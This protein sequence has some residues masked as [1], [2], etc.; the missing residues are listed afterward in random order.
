MYSANKHKSKK[1]ARRSRRRGKSVNKKHV[2]KSAKRRSPKRKSP[3]RKS[4]KRKSPKR[5]SLKGGAIRLPSEYF[6]KMSGRYFDNGNNF[7][8]RSRP[9]GKGQPGPKY[10]YLY[11]NN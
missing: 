4:P 11:N 10:H 2:I 7:T 8:M 3:K 1:V 5:K 9:K 6:G